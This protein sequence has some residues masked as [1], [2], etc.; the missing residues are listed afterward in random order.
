MNGLTL[1]QEAALT[2]CY[3]HQ[4]DDGY[5]FTDLGMLKAFVALS[6]RGMINMTPDWG[7]EPVLFQGMLPAGA[8]HYATARRNRRKFVA[9][10]DSA[11]EL[12][13]R[14]A[15][16]DKAMKDERARFVSTDLGSKGDYRDL[17]DAGLLNVTWADIDVPWT[18]Q[19]TGDGRSYAEGWFF[20]Q[21]DDGTKIV[22]SPTFINSP[23]YNNENSSSASA[24]AS[25]EANVAVTLGMTIEAIA[26]LDDV[27]DEAKNAAQK[28]A[29]DLDSAAKGKDKKAFAEK[30]EGIASV[31]KSS[32][33]LAGVVLPFIQNAIAGFLG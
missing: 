6:D 12:M 33:T 2:I 3:M 22:N 28:A 14:L 32:A 20:D 1:E 25:A 15:V 26:G 8:E 21:M 17:Q 31:I 7:Q 10:S 30:L 27:D 5:D 13:M 24:S 9:V 29:I 4:D 23:T 18:A 11:D 19:L 16:Q